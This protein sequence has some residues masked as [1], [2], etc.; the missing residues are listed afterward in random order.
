MYLNSH[1]KR[2]DS[3]EKQ[4]VYIEISNFKF[5]ARQNSPGIIFSKKK[6]SLKGDR[7]L[8]HDFN[9]VLDIIQ[10]DNLQINENRILQMNCLASRIPLLKHLT[11]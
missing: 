4:R 10:A 11:Y 6:G 7:L 5:T 8:G 1:E 2:K 3:L 9:V